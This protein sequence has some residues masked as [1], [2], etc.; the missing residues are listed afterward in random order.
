MEVVKLLTTG[1]IAQRLKVKPSRVARVVREYSI[2]PAALAG[3]VRLFNNAAMAEIRR[4][5][6]TIDAKRAAKGG[7]K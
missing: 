6:N 3:V 7:A 2:Q 5:L 1:E 4:V